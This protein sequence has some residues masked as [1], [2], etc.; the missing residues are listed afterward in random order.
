V[1]S[2]PFQVAL[3]S[4]LDAEFELGNTYEV[5]HAPRLERGRIVLRRALWRVPSR[6]ILRL[7]AGTR[8]DAFLALRDFCS[9][10]AIPTHVFMR[11]SAGGDRAKYYRNKT[12][13]KPMFFDAGN[14]ALYPA[15]VRLAK[16]AEHV[17]LVEA[18]PGPNN[19]WLERVAGQR[20]VSELQ[21]EFAL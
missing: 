15:L 5:A 19:Q 14:P 17:V 21:V 10:Y 1:L 6:E 4:L 16:L 2:N 13:R 20:R 8:S 9:A 7:L 18:M 11:P 3:P 12:F